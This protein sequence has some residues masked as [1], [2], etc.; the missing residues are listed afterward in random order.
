MN[1]K[2]ILPVAI[3]ILSSCYTKKEVIKDDIK[4]DEVIVGNQTEIINIG[5]DKN[6]SRIA[7]KK[8]ELIKTY[9]GSNTIYHDIVRTK[10]D[11]RFDYNKK[12]VLGVAEILLKP[13]YYTTDSLTLDAQGFEI[14]R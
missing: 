14:R 10:L 1:Y 13:Y 11:L 2:Y 3:L 9:K 5:K 6:E 12:Y 4:I 7:S 8:S